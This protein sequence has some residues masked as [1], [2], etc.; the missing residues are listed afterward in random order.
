MKYLCV[1]YLDKMKMDAL[2]KAQIDTVMSEC[3]AFMEEFYDSG[4]EQA[5]DVRS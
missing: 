1:G 4:K 2:S 5:K 3:P